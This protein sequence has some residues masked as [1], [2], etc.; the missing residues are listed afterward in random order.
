MRW[1]SGKRSS[2]SK[3]VGLAAAKPT[4][5]PYAQATPSELARAAALFPRDI[6]GTLPTARDGHS[7]VRYQNKSGCTMV[8][9]FGGN[10]A[11]GPLNDCWELNLSM[12][13]TFHVL[14]LPLT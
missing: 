2:F 1:K 4:V 7:A 3:N 10:S 13:D 6:D 14:R 8:V 9:I 5:A 11:A 12:I